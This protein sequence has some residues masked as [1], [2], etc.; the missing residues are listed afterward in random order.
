MNRLR[1]E[2][3][4]DAMVGRGIDILRSTP[5]TPP[6]PG[7]RQ[8]VWAAVEYE[9][10]R[11]R[12][13]ETLRLSPLRVFAL[14]AALVLL[15]GTAGAVIGHSRLRPLLER[16]VGGARPASGPEDGDGAAARPQPPRRM[17]RRDA[18]PQPIAPGAGDHHAAAPAIAPPSSAERRRTRVSGSRAAGVALAPSSHAGG[19]GQVLDAMVALRRDHDAARAQDLLARYLAGHPRGALREEAMVL[20]IEA[21]DARDDQSGVERLVKQY[22]ASYPAGRFRP[23]VEDQLKR[24]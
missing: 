22:R 9:A 19:D 13:K 21:A 17:P 1:D 18:M 2:S 23:Y 6:M 10:G 11:A 16:L 24:P 14:I 3:A 4:A 15:G 5:A 7:V 8:R 12:R 20:S